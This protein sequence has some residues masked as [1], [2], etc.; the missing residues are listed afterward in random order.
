METRGVFF[1][2][3]HLGKDRMVLS[4]NIEFIL[5]YNECRKNESSKIFL[6]K[7]KKSAKEVYITKEEI[8]SLIYIRRNEEERIFYSP[9]S[10]ATLLKRSD[11]SFAEYSLVEEKSDISDLVW[12]E[13]I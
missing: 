1:M 5:D 12:K 9:I 11:D 2:L 10:S 7:L 6:N 13:K 8:K 3:L 4:E